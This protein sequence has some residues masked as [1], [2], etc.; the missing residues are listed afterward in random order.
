MTNLVVMG[1]GLLLLAGLVAVVLQLIKLR[2]EIAAKSPDGASPASEVT[3]SG[4]SPTKGF[5]KPASEQADKSASA[6]APAAAPEPSTPK[7]STPD[8]GMVTQYQPGTGEGIGELEEQLKQDPENP[9][10]LDWLAF[11]YYSNKKY[12]EAID[13]Y[14]RAI[15]INYD[16]EHQHYYLANSYYQLGQ[17][18][19]AIEEW[20]VV[21]ELK[22][23]SKLAHNAEERIE[24]SKK[25]Q[26]V[27]I[28]SGSKGAA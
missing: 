23:G 4:R 15:A 17:L 22:P 3:S 25:G 18:E 5:I 6:A 12:Q 14:R 2:K 27:A 7:P 1:I 21:L 28:E 11:M 10:L 8:P 19:R 16:N 24:K 20:E 26:A 9:D 13:T